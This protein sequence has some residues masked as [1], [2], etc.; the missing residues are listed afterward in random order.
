MLQ[1]EEEVRQREEKFQTELAA[2]N[3]KYGKQL[4]F[5]T[6]PSEEEIEAR[7]KQMYYFLLSGE[8]DKFFDDLRF[9]IFQ[10]GESEWWSHYSKEL[11]KKMMGVEDQWRIE[12][13]CLND[14]GGEFQ[15]GDYKY[16]LPF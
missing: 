2:A 16:F 14:I 5:S 12:H 4:D 7:M 6:K 9:W 13:R 3:E 1:K 11:Q 10:I 15:Q 8:D